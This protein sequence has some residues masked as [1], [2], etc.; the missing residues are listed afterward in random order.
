MENSI[1]PD[2]QHEVEMDFMMAWASRDSVGQSAF[3]TG[4]WNWAYRARTA[5]EEPVLHA[6]HCRFL[7][8]FRMAI[9][10]RVEQSN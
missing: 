2:F 5:T 6:A 3:E 7:S 1:S 8:K 9:P 10:D 4:S